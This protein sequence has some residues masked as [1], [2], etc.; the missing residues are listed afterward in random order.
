MADTE[1]DPQLTTK[2]H[3]RWRGLGALI[4][5]L[6]YSFFFAAHLAMVGT[7]VYLKDGAVLSAGT[8]KVYA[9]MTLP[10]ADAGG[11]GTGEG[12][13]FLLLHRPFVAVFEGVWSMLAQDAAMAQKHAFG[14]LRA[15]AGALMVVFLYNMLLWSGLGFWNAV[16]WAAVGGFST[17][18]VVFTALP[19]TGVF[20]MLGLTAML[21]A[22]ARGRRA[23]WWEF[24]IAALYTVLCS[25]WNLIAVIL[26]VFVRGV[27]RWRMSQS[28]YG[29]VRAMLVSV[30]MLVLLMLGAMRI[31]GWMYPKSSRKPVTALVHEGT[32]Q[33]EKAG[34]RLM[35]TPWLS[36]LEDVFLNSVVAPDASAV[37]TVATNEPRTRRVITLA[38]D[39]GTVIGFERVLWAAWLLL[40]LLGMAGLPGAAEHAGV[41]TGALILLG[42]QMV[43]YGALEQA[44]QRL[45]FSWAWLPPLIIATAVGCG[46][47]L[48]RYSRLRVPVTVLLIFFASMLAMRNFGFIQRIADQIR[49]IASV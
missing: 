31:Q 5:T 38:E 25:H 24:S 49:L 12:G 2:L 46:R 48:Q 10:A 8:A 15:L 35:H 21:A 23:R 3:R 19:D 44:G 11:R 42:W 17:A 18:S 20:T 6:F 26:L 43:Y 40:L 32:A 29:T 13:A 39:R 33:L 1:I 47:A 34:E 36:R 45:L 9:D 4:F 27:R 16:L 14:S 28:S 30:C 41:A 7:T 37:D 22:M